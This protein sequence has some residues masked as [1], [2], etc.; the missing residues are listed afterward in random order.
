MAVT[1]QQF[2]PRQVARLTFGGVTVECCQSDGAVMVFVDP[3]MYN[4][5][6][7]AGRAGG[8]TGKLHH[9]VV[10]SPYLD[11]SQIESDAPHTSTIPP[12]LPTL[13]ES[14]PSSP[15]VMVE[16]EGEARSR[17]ETGERVLG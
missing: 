3:T 13:P 7:R 17:M 4:V 1:G 15:T 9:C 8:D 10:I 5:T 2:N 12:A 6:L 11:P 14:S 16:P